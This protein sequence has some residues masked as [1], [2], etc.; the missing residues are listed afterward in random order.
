MGKMKEL[1]I[2]IQSGEAEEF[3][4]VTASAVKD[5]VPAFT[6]EG[7]IYQTDTAINYAKFLDSYLAKQLIKPVENE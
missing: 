7:R 1:S 6:F 4:H 2:M 5:K 3:I